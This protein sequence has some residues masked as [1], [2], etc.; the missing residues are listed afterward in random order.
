[1]TA[2]Q[3]LFLNNTK[4][5]PWDRIVFAGRI[6]S[7]VFNFKIYEPFGF[8]FMSALKAAALKVVGKSNLPGHEKAKHHLQQLYMIGIKFYGYDAEG[9][10]VTNDTTNQLIPNTSNGTSNDNE[11]IVQKLKNNNSFK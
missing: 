1:M 3:E 2:K 9:N 11:V 6:V 8:S 5:I 7:N 4:L 10:L